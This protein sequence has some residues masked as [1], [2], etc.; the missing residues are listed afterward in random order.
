MGPPTLALGLA[1]R[2]GPLFSAGACESIH[3]IG[4]ISSILTG[5]AQTLVNIL[6]AVE[7]LPSR[8]AIASVTR[9]TS[10]GLWSP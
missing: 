2:A 8:V 1:E 9:G 3:S 10:G 6:V 5:I 7:S 4:A